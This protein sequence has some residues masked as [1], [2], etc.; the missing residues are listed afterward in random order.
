MEIQKLLG[1]HTCTCGRTH[2]CKMRA[3][4][5]GPGAIEKLREET[6]EYHKILVVADQNTY[7]VCGEHVK[8][9]LG[10]SLEDLLIYT[11]EGYLITEELY[12]KMFG[13]GIPI[14][15]DG[16]EE[17]MHRAVAMAKQYGIRPWLFCADDEDSVK[18]AVE[19]GATNITCNNPYPAIAY[20]VREGLHK[21]L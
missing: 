7:R 10:D 3:V 14:A 12:E 4:H 5:T 11:G 15:K 16:E 20:L 1:T 8:A 18:K 13:I 19:A 9:L 17:K 2:S 21:L 6:K